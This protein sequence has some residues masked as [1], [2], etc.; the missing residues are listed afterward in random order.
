[1]YSDSDDD[2]ESSQLSQPHLFIKKKSTDLTGQPEKAEGEDVVDRARTSSDLINLSAN[3]SSANLIDLDVMPS[4]SKAAVQPPKPSKSPTDKLLIKYSSS[5]STDESASSEETSL[6]ELLGGELEDDDEEHKLINKSQ[7]TSPTLFGS[8]SKLTFPKTL[9]RE[10]DWN[11]LNKFG[12]IH[13]LE[14]TVHSP[15]LVPFQS[16]YLKNWH[17]Q[18]RLYHEQKQSF[19]SLD[20]RFDSKLELNHAARPPEQAS[21]PFAFRRKQ[22]GIFNFEFDEELFYKVKKLFPQVS[23]EKIRTFM[24]KHHNQEHDV[25]AAT[26]NSLSPKR[27][28][29]RLKHQSAMDKVLGNYIRMHREIDKLDEERKRLTAKDEQ[30]DK[31]SYAQVQIKIKYLKKL[32]PKVDELDLFYMLHNCDMK[33]NN[34]AKK[35]EELGYQ[36][37]SLSE[38]E[39]SLVSSLHFEEVM[40][41]LRLNFDEQ[42]SRLSLLQKDYPL[43]DIYLVKEALKC[44]KFNQNE[45]RKLLDTVDVNEFKNMKPFELDYSVDDSKFIYKTERGTQTSFLDGHVVGKFYR[46]ERDFSSSAVM[47]SQS[48]W[49]GEDGIK[50]KAVKKSLAI[51]PD[52]FNHNGAVKRER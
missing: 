9:E 32:Y 16:K 43:I 15:E 18:Q 45:A 23:D 38:S 20:T 1:M 52:P 36:R 37:I 7:Q 34:V 41:D 26:I 27:E 13:S 5:D 24:Y 19:E 46:V 29:R 8:L 40:P 31:H 35:L 25:I 47:I 14:S 48:T 11:E 17:Q 30:D 42:Q 4:T 51:G 49:T 10:I 39:E 21:E 50:K 28:K 6:G 3:L 33:A 2:S 44:T 12:S 22:Y